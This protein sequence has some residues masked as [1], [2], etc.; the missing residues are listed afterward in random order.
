[1]AHD[2]QLPM[3]YQNSTQVIPK[4][5]HNSTKVVPNHILPNRWGVYE[6]NMLPREELS[7]FLQVLFA[8]VM[9]KLCQ[10][11]W[12]SIWSRDVLSECAL[13]SVVT[14]LALP[15][16][17]YLRPL[18]S[19]KVGGC[20]ALGTAGSEEGRNGSESSLRSEQV[21]PILFTIQVIKRELIKPRSQF[22]PGRPMQ[23]K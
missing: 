1:M 3:W 5:Y 10:V 18:W 20:W 15:Q 17:C 9:S 7:D 21:P 12:V 14:G 23:T 11:F 8:Q 16:W 13:I 4:W 6:V 2:T 22:P 19:E